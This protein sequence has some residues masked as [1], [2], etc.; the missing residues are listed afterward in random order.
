MADSF[1]VVI[2]GGGIAGSA[3]AAQLAKAGKGV[4]VLEQQLTYKDKVRGETFCPWGVRE[5][6]RMGLDD[7]ALAAGG[8][9]ASA[10]PAYD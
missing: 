6:V 4:L 10:Q 7:V 9:Y 5:L 2:I 3:L 1:D 8:E